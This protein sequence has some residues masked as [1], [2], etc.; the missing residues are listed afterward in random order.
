MTTSA[1]VLSNTEELD[2]PLFVVGCAR[3]GTGVLAKA[4]GLSE[5][6]CY[7]EETLLIP[8]YYN[9]RVPIT[10][11]IQYWKRGETLLPILK[12]KI[13]RLQETLTGSDYLLELIPAL[14]CYVKLKDYDLKLPA[15]KRLIDRYNVKLTS[16]DMKFARELHDKYTHLARE[17]IDRMLRVLFKDFQLLS[18]KRKILEKTPIH[19][20]YVGTLK[21]IFPKTRI[22]FIVR[23][24]RDV[25]A[26]Y[27]LNFG[28]KKVHNRTIRHICRTHR[29]IQQ[30]HEQ[31]AATNDPAFH[32]IQYEDMIKQPLTVIEGV[33]N[34]LDLGVSDRVR[35]ALV[36]VKPTRSNWQQ[37]PKRKQIYVETCLGIRRSAEIEPIA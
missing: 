33:F 36:E 27:M 32:F 20:L 12:G 18:G 8:R 9:R 37:L 25:A 30:I 1:D 11:A 34:F 10:L 35:R 4:I 31:L 26:S 28:E 23:N 17:N 22:C 5:Q 13:R 15:G 2:N 6:V 24:G 16:D 14:L 29:R 7:V 19:A 21:R 3:S